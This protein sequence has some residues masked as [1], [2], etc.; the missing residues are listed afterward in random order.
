[1]TTFTYR[2]IEAA[3]GRETTGRVM[4]E[5]E[6]TAVAELKARGL[7]PTAIARAEGASGAGPGAVGTAAVSARFTARGWRIRKAVGRRERV[8]FTRQLAVLVAAGMPLVRGLDL[9]ARQERNLAWRAVIAG[10][11]DEIRYGGTLADGVMRYPKVFDRLYVGMIKAG[12]SGGRIDIVL[13]RLARHLEKSGRIESRVRSSMTYP[14]VIMAVAVSIVAA[15]MT[16]VVPRFEKI[17]ATVLK[18]APLPAL[19]S[20]VLGVSRF[21]EAHWLAL[22]VLAALAAAGAEAAMRTDRGAR[23]FDRLVLRLPVV[24]D[25]LLK[26]AVARFSRT[27]GTML[28]SG[29]PMLQALQL[30]RDACGNRTLAASI[31]DVHR[32]VREGEGVAPTLAA[33]GVF[34]VVVAGMVEVG[35]ETGTLPTMLGHVAD[36]YDE[37]VDTA[38]AGLTSLIEPVMIVLMAVIVGTI[39]VALFLPIIR[40]VQL[41]S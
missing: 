41:M 29:V 38:V 3:T 10:L 39:V 13:E 4:G 14:L 9:L 31:E 2:A 8:V 30:T 33:G 27:L 17:F 1:M 34:P 12:E 16:F 36:M 25:L 5:R 26:T 6:E 18:G 20:G 22:L 23:A 40:I 28:L 21:V 32:R 37:E 15:L 11:A 7:H 19:T 24:G 35:E